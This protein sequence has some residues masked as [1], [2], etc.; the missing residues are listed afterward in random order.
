MEKNQTGPVSDMHECPNYVDP[1]FPV[2]M[3][4][5]TK[6]D[7]FPRGRGF[8]DIHWHDEIQFTYV[9][10]GSLVMRVEGKD[11][12]LE[13]GD[14]IFVN[15]GL[16]HVTT[17]MSEDGEYI[18]FMYPEKLLGFFPGSRM[19]QNYV[20][21]YLQ[22]NQLSVH[23]IKPDSPENRAV[24]EEL[25][26]LREVFDHSRQVEAFEYEVAVRLTS[27][28]LKLI[29]Q[30]HGKASKLSACYV[31]RQARMKVMM[32]YIID[33]YGEPI[34]LNEIAES[35]SISVEECRRCFR[36][37]IR[38]TPVHYL[39]AYRV[40]KGMELLRTTDLDVTEIAF[41]VGFNDSSYFIQAFKK[42]VGMTPKQ[43]RNKI[44]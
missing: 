44:F 28:W 36:T 40:M 33:H 34:T 30:V 9:S 42:K 43:Y 22:K 7:M 12:E 3:H 11:Y 5:I 37:I 13:E 8:H 35:A 6:H 2:S 4:T 25:K 1:A 16:I 20:L 10:R 21:P 24:L 15:T 23:L 17:D 41:R 26:R 14:A 29:R 27:I 18:G 39:V 19:E 38:E 31:Q 32:Q